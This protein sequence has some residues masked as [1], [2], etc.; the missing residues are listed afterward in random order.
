MLNPPTTKIVL[1]PI[2]KQNGKYPIKLRVTFKQKQKFYPCNIDLTKEEFEKVFHSAKPRKPEKAIKDVA[3]GIEAKAKAAYDTLKVFDFAAFEKN[4]YEI[5]GGQGD[6]YDLFAETYTEMLSDDRIGTAIMYNTVLNSLKTFRPTL[7]FEQITPEFLNNY[8]KYML[9]ASKSITTVGIY[10]RHLRAIYN[11]GVAENLASFETYPFGSNKYVIPVGNNIKKALSIEEVAKIFQYETT[12]DGWER[13]AK[14]FWCFSYLCNG[15]NI[16]DIAK[17]K[18]KNISDGEIHYERS[19]TMRTNRGKSNSR[20]SIPILPQTQRIINT[21]GSPDAS[22]ENYIFPIISDGMSAL[23]IKKHVQQFTKNMN[24]YTKK[25][26]HNLGIDKNVTTYVARHSYATVL[27]RS[28]ASVEAI[29]ENLGHKNVSTTKSYLDSF[30]AESR[31]RNAEALVAFK[32]PALDPGESLSIQNGND[33]SEQR[34][35]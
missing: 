19:K 15:M 4:F 35:D 26:A 10:L 33:R 25:I 11:K 28:G 32:N 20:I 9:S 21:W 31:R 3:L 22:A 17:L 8:E 34:Y 29:S 7:T 6:V 2:V 12:S 16:M 23:Q 14:D 5:K 1:V 18:Y 13:K 27:K 24:D 30:E